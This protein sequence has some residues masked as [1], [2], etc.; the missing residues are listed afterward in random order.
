MNDSVFQGIGGTIFPLDPND[1]TDGS[2]APLDPARHTLSELFKAAINSEFA[3]VWP[4]VATRSLVGTLPVQDVLEIE[5]SAVVM[6][7]R[8]PAF[9]LLCVHRTGT[10]TFDQITMHEERLTQQWAVDYILGP[11]DVAD[12]RKLT[13]V[14]VA[15]AKLIKIV[16]R[17]RGHKAYQSGALQFFETDGLATVEVKSVEGPGQ[18]QFAGDD[19]LYYATTIMLETTEV[20]NDNLEAY[21][22]GDGLDLDIGIGNETEIVHGLMYARV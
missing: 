12:V 7:Q 13:D 9:P 11:L 4:I 15:V 5:P 1:F 3:E 20:T 2:L 16:V 6:Q 14:A 10:A 18:A 17:Q 19:K 22:T 21:P 8:K